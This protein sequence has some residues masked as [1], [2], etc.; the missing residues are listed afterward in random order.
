[1]ARGSFAVTPETVAGVASTLWG[2][3]AET[4]RQV[5]GQVAEA[6]AGLFLLIMS[7]VLSLPLLGE[8]PTG[9]GRSKGLG[10]AVGSAAAL[11]LGVIAFVWASRE[12]ESLARRTI[13]LL[14]KQPA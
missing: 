11:L 13:E 1:V 3:N 7:V 12:A 2:Y 14:S 10:W 4:V 8:G 5:S 6:K 9:A